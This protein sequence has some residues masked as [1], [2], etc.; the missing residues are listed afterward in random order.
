MYNH[1]CSSCPNERINQKSVSARQP[2]DFFHGQRQAPA[3]RSYKA[4]AALAVH[5]LLLDS[6][7][8][9]RERLSRAMFP[10]I[11]SNGRRFSSAHFTAVLSAA[12]DKI[13]SNSNQGY[14]V[15]VSKKVAR[16]SVTRHLI[17]RRV[18]HALKT[19]PLPRTLI[20][21]PRPSIVGI[22]YKDIK[23]ELEN[24]LSKIYQYHKINL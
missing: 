5:V 22:H 2:T 18:L 10:A 15:V 8:P 11:L 16:L 6:V 17:K 14:A 21:F 3:A 4:A 23:T 9:R 24:L 7:F 19:L 20:L 13:V 1:F 12:K